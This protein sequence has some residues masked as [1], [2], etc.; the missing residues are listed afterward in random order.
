MQ[1]TVKIKPQ[2]QAWSKR[3]ALANWYVYN[4]KELNLGIESTSGNVASPRLAAKQ[5]PNDVFKTFLH[6]GR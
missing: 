5:N 4:A 1:K 3:Q 6:E 2:A